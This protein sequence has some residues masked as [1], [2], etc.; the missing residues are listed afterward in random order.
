MSSRGRLVALV[1]AASLAAVGCSAL[2]LGGGSPSAATTAT[3]S[4]A[5]DVAPI[6]RETCAGCHQDGADRV[7]QIMP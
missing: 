4:F 2:V 3:P 5:R 1:F 6:V 7:S